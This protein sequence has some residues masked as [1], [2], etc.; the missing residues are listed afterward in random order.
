[1]SNP[2]RQ[3]TAGSRAMDLLARQYLTT[4]SEGGDPGGFMHA[5]TLKVAPHLRGVGRVQAYPHLW[6]EAVGLAMLRECSP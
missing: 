1:M 4:L 3:E 6:G 5:L 2:A